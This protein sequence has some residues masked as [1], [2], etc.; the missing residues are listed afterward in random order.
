MAVVQN[1]IINRAS[2]SVG[3]SVFSKWKKKNTLRSKSIN[4]Y[5]EP[6]SPQVAARAIFKNCTSTI[7]QIRDMFQYSSAGKASRLS[8]L[9][10]FVKQNRPFF[11]ADSNIIDVA[12]VSSLKFSTGKLFYPAFMYSNPNADHSVIITC[13][14]MLTL[15]VFP[16]PS[17]LIGI[18]FDFNAKL[19]YCQVSDINSVQ[20]VTVQLPSSSSGHLIFPFCF[21]SSGINKESGISISGNSFYAL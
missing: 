19:M 5:P 9:N 10:W 15:D 14:H 4:P 1:P 8:Y 11:T 3:N 2:G 7:L 13:S 12:N 18:L 21:N 16:N 17:Y 6:S 20:S